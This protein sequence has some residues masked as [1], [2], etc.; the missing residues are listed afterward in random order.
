MKKSDKPVYWIGEPPLKCDLCG[1]GITTVFVDGKTVYGPWA[2][3]CPQC[4]GAFGI[5]LGLGK[6]QRF[7]LQIDAKFLKVAG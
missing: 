5:G 3:M 4:H 6:G 7:K 2:N 1:K